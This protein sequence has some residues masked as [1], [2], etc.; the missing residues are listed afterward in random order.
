MKE[1]QIQNTYIHTYITYTLTTLFRYLLWSFVSFDILILT[2]LRTPTWSCNCCRSTSFCCSSR[3]S[4][5]SCVCVYV[6]IYVWVY[7]CMYVWVYECMFMYV[8]GGSFELALSLIDSVESVHSIVLIVH[9]QSVWEYECMSVWVYECI[10]TND[11]ECMN[12]NWLN[13]IRN[14]NYTHTDTFIHSYTHTLIH[15]N[16]HTLILLTLCCCYSTDHHSFV[17]A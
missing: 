3:A 17:T 11:Y 4:D 16:T 13:W 12:A 15:S 14:F 10:W 6:C 7:V 8:P 2:S 9:Y 1:H 5:S